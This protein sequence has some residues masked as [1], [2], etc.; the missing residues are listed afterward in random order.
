[1]KQCTLHTQSVALA[2]TLLESAISNSGLLESAMSLT[3]QNMICTKLVSNVKSMLIMSTVLSVISSFIPLSRDA[4]FIDVC[5]CYWACCSKY[6]FIEKTL[7][8]F[9]YIKICT[10]K[11]VIILLTT[12]T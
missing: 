7:S 10:K 2:N 12:N 6:Y 4:L 11:N 9:G 1:M 3:T 5:A 8:M